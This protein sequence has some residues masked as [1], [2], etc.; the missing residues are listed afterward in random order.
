MTINDYE[1]VYRLW[2][3][4]GITL[5]KSD[6]REEIEKMLKRNPNTCL[7]GEKDGKIIAAVM[8]GFDGRR[9]Y[10]HHLAVQPSLQGQ[11]YGGQLLKEL[12]RRFTQMG[13]KKVHLFVVDTNKEVI[14]FYEKNGYIQRDEL[15]PMSK[16]LLDEI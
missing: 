16:T 1:E 10:I 5:K 9:G 4:A 15:I 13:V 6:E 12:E 2:A 3:S 8:G 7:V 14:G 11:G